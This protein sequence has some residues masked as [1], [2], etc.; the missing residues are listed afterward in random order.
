MLKMIDKGEAPSFSHPHLWAAPDG[1]S[2]YQWAGGKPLISRRPYAPN[3][4]WKLVPG[5]DG[6]GNWTEV[7]TSDIAPSSQPLRRVDGWGASAVVDGTGYYFGGRIYSRSDPN[8]DDIGY[9]HNRITSLNMTT[10]DWTTNRASG[11][12]INGTM[13]GGSAVPVPAPGLGGRSLVFVL[14][15]WI[16]NP[17]IASLRPF[18]G[19]E[20]NYFDFS[21]VTFYDPYLDI[22]FVQQASGDV[23]T[24]R[25]QFCTVGVLGTNGTFEMYESSFFHENT[26][27]AVLSFM[28]GGIDER[29]WQ[30]Y[31]DIYILSI[32]GFVWH[33][34][35]STGATPRTEHTCNHVG[36]GQMLTLGGL[37]NSWSFLNIWANWE[38]PDPWVQGIGVFDM[39]ELVWKTEYTPATSTYKTP[40]L[41]SDWYDRGYDLSNTSPF[42]VSLI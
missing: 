33:K 12:G 29:T 4:V 20:S 28:Y 13:R 42:P 35:P 16:P 40:D 34:A 24:G 15:G 6:A 38:M 2:I 8:V 27:Y 30:T 25:G 3:G 10:G 23:P 39:N 36:G 17:D 31:S 21:N 11:L 19:H 1:R 22:W 32:P 9:E 18:T 41:V 37:D 14:G 7:I 5:D 26:A